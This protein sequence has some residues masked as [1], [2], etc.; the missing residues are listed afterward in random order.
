MAVLRLVPFLLAPLALVASSSP[1]PAL[2]PAVA[3]PY[4][5][6][7]ARL[8]DGHGRPYRITGT[9]LAPLTSSGMDITGT[10]GEFGPLSATTIVTIR[11]RVNMNAVR[12]PLDASLYLSDFAY[13][14]RARA[15][16]DV[17]NHLEL[18]VILEADTSSPEFWNALA[19]DFCD[20]PNIFFAL[21]AGAT[22]DSVD[23]IRAA[24][25]SQPI[26]ASD[27]DLKDTNLIAEVTPG[28][29]T[30]SD[31]L[32]PIAHVA[33]SRPVLADGMDP[34]FFTG[35]R[36]CSAV[37]TDPAAAA[38]M[39]ERRLTFFDDHN[40]SWTISSF[41]PGKMISDYR[42]LIGT[43]L[44][45]GWTCKQQKPDL[46]VG[47]GV[48]VLSHLWR[49]SPDGLFPVNCMLGGFAVAR[50]AVVSIYGPT[51]A[52]HQ[53][54]PKP[55]TWP[56]HLGGVSIRVTDSKGV[57]RL[58][59]ML[60]AGGGWQIISFMVPPASALGPADVTI[61]RDDGSTTTG[62]I[63]V[64]D[65]APGLW[66]TNAE[67][68]GG[69]VGKV[70]QHFR[71]GRVRVSDAAKPIPLAANVRTTVRMPGTGFRYVHSRSSVQV[72]IGGKPAKVVSFGP[73]TGTPYD[74]Q[75][76]V[77]IPNELKDAGD[78]D[79][80][81]TVDGVLSNVVRLNFGKS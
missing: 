61:V 74:D 52:D 37:P 78:V 71:D 79:V 18:L 14:K 68:R 64:T 43:R 2:T 42:Y 3:G 33:E 62:R 51:L 9:R 40:V 72:T 69:V 47:I 63:V 36:E 38:A 1:P 22:Q 48:A 34:G 26:V 81:F 12:L 25:A 31:E 39:I 80:W 27:P 45:R 19:S 50:G 58:A 35:S 66:T 32:D 7:G 60:Y 29:T 65:V 20:D 41:Q 77:E 76:T 55:G 70:T 24:R 15:V 17:S 10:P 28:Y 67:S 4:H 5:V 30:S 75:L 6:E 57:A 11:Q 21:P 73:D 16:A 49:T 44:E 59:H 13:R 54:S 46:A 8:I 23:A 56:Y 53:E